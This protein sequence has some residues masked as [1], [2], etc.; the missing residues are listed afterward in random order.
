MQE[1]ISKSEKLYYSI[2]EVAEMLHVNASLIRYWEKEFTGIRP[3]KNRK[4]NRLFTKEDISY[5]RKVHTLVKERGMTLDGAKK[6]L[7]TSHLAEEAKPDA[8]EMLEKAKD[9]LT[10]IRKE[11]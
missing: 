6:H 9:F 4:G 7:K 1:A 8:L 5:L 2:G 3:K 10:R 11:L